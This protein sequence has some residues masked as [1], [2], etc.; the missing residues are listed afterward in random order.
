M[1]DRFRP[2]TTTGQPVYDNLYAAG[3]ILAHQDW[4]RTKS[5]TGLAVATS[6]GAI[7]AMIEGSGDRRS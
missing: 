3:S 6:Y 2:V 7:E 4:I 1:D 5:G